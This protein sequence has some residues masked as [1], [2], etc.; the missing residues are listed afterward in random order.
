MSSS[1]YSKKYSGQSKRILPLPYHSY[2]TEEL[3]KK[4][5]EFTSS[6][7]CW[8]KTMLTAVPYVY[9]NKSK[10]THNCWKTI[11]GK[12]LGKR[13]DHENPPIYEGYTR[14]NSDL[15]CV[16]ITEKNFI[17]ASSKNNF[18]EF[19]TFR[20]LLHDDDYE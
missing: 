6:N 17:N 3:Y 16:L 19:V 18:S 14:F 20:S 5:Q 13:K 10:K 2:T 8:I 11:N 15:H 7:K 1:G 4:I 9:T 12:Y